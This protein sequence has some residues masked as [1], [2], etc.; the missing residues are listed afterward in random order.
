MCIRTDYMFPPVVS[1]RALP[2]PDSQALLN[3]HVGFGDFSPTV[4]FCSTHSVQFFF[5][6]THVFH[7]CLNLISC[8][9]MSSIC[10]WEKLLLTWTLQPLCTAWEWLVSLIS[11]FVVDLMNF[12][13]HLA[14][15]CQPI[16]SQS[17]KCGRTK[18]HRA[19]LQPT[20]D[21][22]VGSVETRQRKHPE[23]LKMHKL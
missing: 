5:F 21:A 8:G 18:I 17:S 6:F 1:T 12:F 15:V 2:F 10:T 9:L 3:T 14:V 19:I 4:L 16:V 7:S 22:W 20:T 13:C 11:S 23:Y